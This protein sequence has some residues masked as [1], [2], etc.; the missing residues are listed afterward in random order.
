MPDENGKEQFSEDFFTTVFDRTAK[1][2][3]FEF[4][5]GSPQPKVDNACIVWRNGSS[6]KFWTA[7]STVETVENI[8]LAVAGAV[9]NSGESSFLIPNLLAPEEIGGRG[10]LDFDELNLSGDVKFNNCDCVKI[11]GC[12]SSGSRLT[13]WVDTESFLI[14]LAEEETSMALQISPGFHGIVMGSGPLVTKTIITYSP[15]INS[16]IPVLKFEPLIPG[17]NESGAARWTCP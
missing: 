1:L 15:R 16:V 8:G 13:V 11:S 4:R 3:R 17:Q 9:G 14:L 12:Y 5:A 7:I 10:L 6:V 2:Y